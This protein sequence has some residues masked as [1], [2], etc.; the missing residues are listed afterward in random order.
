MRRNYAKNTN[1]LSAGVI[2]KII[3]LTI[4]QYIN[5][6]NHRPIGRVKYALIYSA[7]GYDKRKYNSYIYNIMLYICKIYTQIEN[8]LNEY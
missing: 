5:S 7:N 6:I 2:G 8:N 1:R 4:L 3:V